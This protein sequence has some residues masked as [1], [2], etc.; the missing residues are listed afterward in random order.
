MQHWKEMQNVSVW[1]EVL[2]MNTNG[3]QPSLALLFIIS[4]RE[5]KRK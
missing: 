4:V 3:P 2:E 1:A 5:R